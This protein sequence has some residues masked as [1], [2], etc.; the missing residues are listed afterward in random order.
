MR[1]NFTLIEI[2]SVH[3]YPHS[4]GLDYLATSERNAVAQLRLIVNEV[5]CDLTVRT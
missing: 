5:K 4:R 1:Y 3:Y 2:D